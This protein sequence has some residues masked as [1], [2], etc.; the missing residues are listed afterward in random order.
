M[1]IWRKGAAYPAPG[2]NVL[3][4]PFSFE[5]PPRLPP[6]S[7]YQTANEFATVA[8]SLKIVGVRPGLHFN[9]RIV[10]PIPVLPWNVGGAELS[11][12]LR[13]G[14]LGE[15]RYTQFVKSVRKGLWG[16]YSRVTAMVSFF[17][18]RSRRCDFIVHLREPSHRVTR[19]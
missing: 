6:S 9:K 3:K 8:Y 14:W 2:D 5:L 4:L 11:Q 12:Q 16:D 13:M 18:P 10:R 17:V 15:W 7:H 1:S 19:F